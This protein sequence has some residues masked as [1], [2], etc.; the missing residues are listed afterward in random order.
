MNDLSF[1]KKC[2]NHCVINITQEDEKVHLKGKLEVN[3]HQTVAS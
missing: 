1:L 2:Y 3:K